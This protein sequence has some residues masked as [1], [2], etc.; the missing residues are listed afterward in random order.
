MIP[1]TDA[2]GERLSS[3]EGGTGP[4]PKISPFPVRP[5][6]AQRVQVGYYYQLRGFFTRP[7]AVGEGFQGAGAA[8]GEEFHEGV[9]SALPVGA[10]IVRMDLSAGVVSSQ[11]VGVLV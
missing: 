7:L 4:V 8:A 1:H 6:A 2:S 5:G 10:N 9:G 11:Q 3:T